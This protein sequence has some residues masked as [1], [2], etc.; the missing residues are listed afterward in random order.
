MH[1]N[2]EVMWR[3]QRGNRKS[4]GLKEETEDRRIFNRLN[5]EKG[6]CVQFVIWVL[7]IR[8]PFPPYLPPNFIFWGGGE[9]LESKVFFYEFT[10]PR[11][12]LCKGINHIEVKSSRIVGK[13]HWRWVRGK[14]QQK[15][16]EEREGM[17]RGL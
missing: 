3:K 13:S 16:K 12:F 8:S 5:Y 14:G 4:A 17:G 2:W 6:S 11:D 10:E 15:E 1:T 7:L 9:D